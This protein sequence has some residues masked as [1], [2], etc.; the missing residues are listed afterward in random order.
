MGSRISGLQIWSMRTLCT[1]ILSS[2]L[3]NYFVTN[4]L[5]NAN[6]QT[7]CFLWSFFVDQVFKIKLDA[8]VCNAYED[9]E[10]REQ[11]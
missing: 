11:H 2:F 4:Q 1:R 7:I 9:A 3:P 5:L 10:E 6:D 8:D